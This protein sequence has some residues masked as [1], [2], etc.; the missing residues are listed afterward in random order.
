MEWLD[1]WLGQRNTKHAMKEE[2]LNLDRE[3]QK[4]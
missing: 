3:N 4:K 2:A 1:I